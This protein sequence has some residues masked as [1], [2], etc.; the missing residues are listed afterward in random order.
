MSHEITLRED[1][2]AEAMFALHPAWHGLGTVTEQAPSSADAL[3]LAGL[4]WEVEQ[5][6]VYATFEAAGKMQRQVLEG[7]QA[8]LR[9]DNHACLGVVGREYEV[10]QNTE[11]F[12]FLDSLDMDGIVRYES[13]FSLSGGK[14]VCVLARMP[15][16]DV[17][18]GNDELCR[19]VLF[20]TTHDGSGSVRV[21]PTSVR[22]VCANTLAVAINKDSRRGLSIHHSGKVHQKLAVAQK[23][24]S[25]ADALFNGFAQAAD[26]LS[27]K[28]MP[29]A[30]FAEFL[31]EL[32]PLP[33]DTD[34]QKRKATNVESLRDTIKQ[35]YGRELEMAQELGVKTNTAWNALNAV[36][37]AVDHAPRTGRR[38]KSDAESRWDITQH[39]SGAELKNRAF[40]LL[41]A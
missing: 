27:Q 14:R 15:K 13:A 18:A 33:D 39:G 36:T 21:F 9:S 1:G 5:A 22:V 34:K 17:I 35:A 8:N 10:V 3:K 41:T 7:Y 29:H 40:E 19:Y 16:R 23:V 30:A 24:L 4:D 2:R 37:Q 20:Q 12:N 28:A 26:I 38:S 31:A 25:R 11:A 32:C 6:P